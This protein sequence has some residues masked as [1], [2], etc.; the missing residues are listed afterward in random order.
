ME[1]NPL[2]NVHADASNRALRHPSTSVLCVCEQRSKDV[3]SLCICAGSTEPCL[4]DNSSNTKSH[5]L[6][7]TVFTLHAKRAPWPLSL[8]DTFAA[9]DMNE[10][11]N[12]ADRMASC[13][14]CRYLI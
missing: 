4:L 7:H 1:Q 13:R 9:N 8:Q 14:P 3:V 11:N 2:L 12:E 10:A 5:V 6:A